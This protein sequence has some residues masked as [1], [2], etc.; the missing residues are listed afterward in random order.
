MHSFISGQS[1]VRL[2]ICVMD[3]VEGKQKLFNLRWLVQQKIKAVVFASVSWLIF[4]VNLFQA[5]HSFC[6]ST[7]RQYASLFTV[8]TGAPGVAVILT[9]IWFCFVSTQAHLKE[10]LK[11]DT[12]TL[13]G[14]AA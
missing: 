8:K 5:W 4:L 14:V 2:I 11:T 12:R 7:P 1:S 9:S 13:Q 3:S 6:S 10:G